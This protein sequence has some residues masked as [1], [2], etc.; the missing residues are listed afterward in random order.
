[1][2]F[3]SPAIEF[4]ARVPTGERVSIRV[5]RASR[6]PVD[7]IPSPALFA[8]SVLQR[9]ARLA[10]SVS[11]VI[12]GTDATPQLLHE[13]VSQLSILLWDLRDLSENSILQLADRLK[14]PSEAVVSMLESLS[15]HISDSGDL[16]DCPV[17]LLSL[18]THAVTLERT[19]DL[20]CSNRGVVMRFI[21]S[22]GCAPTSVYQV[23]SLG[24]RPPIDVAIA[25]VK[26][27]DS[28]WEGASG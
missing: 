28:I 22:S 12:G 2:M 20:R 1:M 26:T 19:T 4:G 24:D 27:I 18:R 17:G 23:W 14:N 5:N 6:L 16:P 3:P 11:A 13:V 9:G 25:A 21:L 15:S 10:H 7:G 8:E